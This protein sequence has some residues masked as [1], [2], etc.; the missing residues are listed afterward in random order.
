MNYCLVCSC[1]LKSPVNKYCSNRCQSKDRYQK[2]V[3]QWKA[4]QVN[5][6]RG[7]NAKGISAHIRRYLEEKFGARCSLCGWDK[8]NPITNRVPLE[9][10][11][12]NG[13]PEDNREEN[14]RVICPNCHSLSPNYRN[15]N[16]GHGRLWRKNKYKKS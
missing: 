5:G 7:V 3:L 10:D 16:K 14:L 4:G 2:Y 1:K 11:H 9:I 12:I 6:S 8:I 15:L 13:D